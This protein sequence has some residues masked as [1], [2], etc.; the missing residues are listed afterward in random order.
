MTI[1]EFETK[2]WSVEDIRVIVRASEKSVVSD[3]PYQN[4]A[5]ETWSVTEFIRNRIRPFIS[6]H[7]V[8]VIAGDGEEPHGRTILRSIRKTY[9]GK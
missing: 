7:E 5:I 6:D 1:E 2:V 9:E 8:L 4:A 3:Y